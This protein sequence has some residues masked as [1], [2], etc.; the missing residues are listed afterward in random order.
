M[1]NNVIQEISKEV[2]SQGLTQKEYTQLETIKKKAN[3][4]Q[5]QY[6]INDLNKYVDTRLQEGGF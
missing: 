1:V 5:I 6:I 4:G 2:R 3:I